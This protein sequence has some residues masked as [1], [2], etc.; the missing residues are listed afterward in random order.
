MPESGIT[1]TMIATGTKSGSAIAKI[2][3]AIM[4][5]PIPSDACTVAPTN[6]TMTVNAKSQ[7]ERPATAN[8]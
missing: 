1:A 6:T 2:G 3:A 4:P 5:R 8:T 7:F